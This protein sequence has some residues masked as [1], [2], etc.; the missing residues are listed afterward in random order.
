ME[1]QSSMMGRIIFVIVAALLQAGCLDL[2]RMAASPAGVA[3]AAG[4]SVLN[5]AGSKLAEGASTGASGGLV[6]ATDTVAE[7]DRILAETGPQLSNASRDD[8]VGL[9]DR[10]KTSET[11]AAGARPSTA[12]TTPLDL[13]STRLQGG[14]GDH[15]FDYRTVNAEMSQTGLGAI[16]GTHRLRRMRSDLELERPGVSRT[17][18]DEREPWRFVMSENTAFPPRF[19]DAAVLRVEGGV[20]RLDH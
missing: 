7:L 12:P 17:R 6:S 19:D 10:L 5:A 11:E 2:L 15:R 14:M 3:E 4:G 8:L 9:R 18:L 1:P 16:S 20:I 13:E